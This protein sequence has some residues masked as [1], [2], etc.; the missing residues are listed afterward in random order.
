M[1]T[2]H[3]LG[4]IIVE[5]ERDQNFP[6][7]SLLPKQTPGETYKYWWASGWWGDQGRT[8]HCV[9]YSWVHWIEDGPITHF[10]ENR[11]FDPSYEKTG[12]HQSLFKTSDVY[13]EAQ[14]L[15]RWPGT[16]YDGT[17]VRA[18]AK[19]LQKRGVIGEY[20]W[21]WDIDT[22]VNALLMLGP[23]VV[24]TW[25]YTSMFYP[26]DEHVIKVGGGKAGGHAYV[27]NGVNL[28]KGLIRIKNSWGRQW[29][30]KGHAYISISDF[31]RLLHEHGEACIATELKL[32]D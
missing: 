32:E 20:R 28:D 22:V 7:R 15:D 29:G 11:D 18:G 17:S 30:K 10:Y 4:R 23:I 6:M 24:G 13:N 31:E 16:N 12:N 9:A 3:K 2:E 1:D 27:L 21:A 25:W 8:P 14:K 26:D 5:D 19:V